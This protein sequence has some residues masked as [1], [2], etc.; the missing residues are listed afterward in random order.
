[1]VDCGLCLREF[2]FP[3]ASPGASD[4]SKWSYRVIGPFALPDYARGG[5]SAAL[6]MRLF[7][8]LIG[9]ENVLTWSAGQELTL[10]NATKVEADFILWHQ[11]RHP[12]GHD[13]P[14]VTIFGEAK[15]FGRDVFKSDDID[16]MKI[17][18]E[19]FPGTVLVFAT[20][21]A[22]DELTSKEVRDIAKL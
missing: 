6:A 21:K 5:Y 13:R 11:R 1:K 8:S 4:F 2:D 19:R 20:M 14:T 22:P 10:D 18:A 17:L 3:T 7:A 12:F 16:R 15:S 9:F